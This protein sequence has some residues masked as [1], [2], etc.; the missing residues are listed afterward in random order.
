MKPIT[1]IR[2]GDQCVTADQV[3]HPSPCLQ[4][5]VVAETVVSMDTSGMLECWTGPKHDYEHPKCLAWEYKTD[6][7][8]YEFMKVVNINVSSSCHLRYCF[9]FC[10]RRR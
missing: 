1:L 10:R 6:T 8:L 9:S 3:S 2:V 4:Y 7:D 5:N